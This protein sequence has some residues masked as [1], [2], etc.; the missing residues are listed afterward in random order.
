MASSVAIAWTFQ[1]RT[2]WR[3][4]LGAGLM[5]LLLTLMSGQQSL[6]KPCGGLAEN[7]A[8]IIA[9]ELARSE[10]DLQAIFGAPGMC[11]DQ[12]IARM[13]SINWMDVLLFIPVYGTFLVSFFLGA[14]TWNISL[15]AIGVKL[16]VAA[17]ATDYLENLC[18]M[19]LTPQLDASSIWM[20]LLPWATGAKWLA[21][22]GAAAVAGLIFVTIRPRHLLIAAIPAALVCWLALFITIAALLAP[23]RFGAVLSPAIGASWVLFLITAITQAF[24]SPSPP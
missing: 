12:M 18:L 8:P 5:I 14:R 9:F 7:Y 15:A 10:G 21:L 11:R 17:V 13:D 4:C 20:T 3:V 16:A 1:P 2:A 6:A 22:A 24:R 19:L 23:A